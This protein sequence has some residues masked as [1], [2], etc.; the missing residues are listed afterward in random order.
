MGD[1]QDDFWDAIEGV[2]PATQQ[3]SIRIRD[4]FV[5]AGVTAL[6]KM[7]FDELKVSHLAE[8][9]G[10]SVGSFYTRFAD[11]DAF[12]GAL[13]A[14]AIASITREFVAHFTVD[15]LQQSERN[16]ALGQLVDLLSDIFTSRYR[17]VLRES[18]LRILDPDDPWARMRQSAQEITTIL[19]DALS[20]SFPEYGE[21]ETH[22]RL[23][24]AFQ[25]IVGVLQNDLINDYHV[26]STRDHSV[27]HG[28]KDAVCAY[29]NAPIS[30]PRWPALAASA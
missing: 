10:N 4:E 16:E 20:H 15:K 27:R 28:L 26:F 19:N 12:I 6:N 14:Y 23:R 25:L 24:F 3:R 8:L 22:I 9:S 5:E 29:M 1:E 17:G 21:A 11:K 13:R 2:Q 18:L 7:R 30:Q